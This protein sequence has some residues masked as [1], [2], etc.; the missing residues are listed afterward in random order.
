MVMVLEI[1][2]RDGSR[3]HFQ[4]F[5]IKDAIIKAFESESILFD[6]AIYERVIQKI[7]NKRTVAV[8]D[9]QDTIEHELYNAR[10]FEVM[11]SFMMYRLIHKMQREQILGINE[12]TTYINAI[13]T[14]EEYINGSDWRIKANSNTGYSNAGL[15]NN[16]AG[17][18]IANYWL[19]KIY[20]KEEGYAHRNGDYH[21][22]DLVY[23]DV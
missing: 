15:V 5:K 18:I 16:S 9:I 12:D 14:V 17:K 21:I 23:E 1:L 2:K 22:H 6:N 19:D 7:S 3:Q 11:K 4:A 13:Q 20:S 10:Y 8:E